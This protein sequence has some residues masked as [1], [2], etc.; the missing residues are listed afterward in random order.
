MKQLNCSKGNGPDAIPSR[1]IKV[2]AEP[3]TQTLTDMFN[4][5][6]RLGKLPKDWTAANIVPIFKK[7]DKTNTRNYRPVSLTSIICKMLERIRNDKLVDYFN[8]NNIIVDNQHGFHDRRSCKTQLLCS[9][10]DSSEAI[11][12]G[13]SVDIA[14]LD[15]SR[16][17]D[18]VPHGKL[19]Q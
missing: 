11:D 13:C 10:H 4:L 3:L 15:I 9:I 8:V 18:S 17:F 5:S 1:I 19:L 7:G 2:C 16:A 6:L 12:K 14:F